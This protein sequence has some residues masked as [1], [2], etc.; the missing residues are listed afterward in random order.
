MTGYVLPCVPKRTLNLGQGPLS[1]G[2]QDVILADRFEVIHWREVTIV[3][4]VHAHSLYG[5]ANSVDI[6]MLPQS[7]SVDDPGIT[8]LDQSNYLSVQLASGTLVGAILTMPA[9][10][11]NNVYP[12]MIQV[13]ARATWNGAGS[14]SATVS[15]DI[16]VKDA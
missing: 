7:T 1:G 2:T 6:F 12:P 11:Y 13:G 10:G 5:T 15:V 3:V 8:F 16:V 9:N 4:R 14:I